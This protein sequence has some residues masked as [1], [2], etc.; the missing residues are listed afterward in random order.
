M[1]LWC[2]AVSIYTATQF[3]EKY[4]SIKAE[5]IVVMNLAESR[6]S[7]GTLDD[8]AIHPSA[9]R[10]GIFCLNFIPYQLSR[11]VLKTTSNAANLSPQAIKTNSSL[12]LLQYFLLF[13]T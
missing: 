4:R 10:A 8:H 5:D 6:E 13:L 7:E 9:P 1:A 12:P 3:K 2:A 11:L